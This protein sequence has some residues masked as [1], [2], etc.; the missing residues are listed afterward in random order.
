VSKGRR[1]ARPNVLRRFLAVAAGCVMGAVSLSAVIATPSASAEIYQCGT[2]SNY[3]DGFYHNPATHSNTLEGA[4][5][6]IVNQFGAVCDTDRS[7]PNPG[8]RTIGS[9]F[10]TAWVMIAAYDGK[11][12]AQTG[13]IRGY[14]SPQ[15]EWAEFYN[16]VSGALYNR[17]PANPSLPNGVKHAYRDLWSNGCGCIVMSIDGAEVTQTNFNPYADWYAGPNGDQFSPQFSGETTYTASDIPGVPSSKTAFSA[18]G[19]QQF[20]NNALNSMPCT[21]TYIN[22]NPSRWAH[23]ASSCTAF[24]IWTSNT[25]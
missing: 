17:F 24:D 20:S 10:T 13:F 21:M 7:A 12:W 14:N 16:P 8:N 15:Y 23:S 19:A 11:G 5:G 6:Y 3:F 9:N 1:A 2:R 18:L 4:S 25:S 22:S